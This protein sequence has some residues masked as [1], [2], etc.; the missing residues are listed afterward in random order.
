MFNESKI[1]PDRG[2]RKTEFAPPANTWVKRDQEKVQQH[3]ETNKTLT[4]FGSQPSKLSIS[5]QPKTVVSPDSPFAVSARPQSSSYGLRKW[6]TFDDN[7]LHLQVASSGKKKAPEKA[8]MT[9]NK[10]FE[11]HVEEKIKPHP[12]RFYYG[13]P[14]HHYQNKK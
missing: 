4:T 13:L 7:P 8:V 6:K 12:S 10:H 3:F 11:R 1:L 2:Y 14:M 5:R 9:T